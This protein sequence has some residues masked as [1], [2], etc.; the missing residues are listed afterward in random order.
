[1]N[2]LLV[3]TTRYNHKNDPMGATFIYEQVEQLRL[4]FDKVLV[5]AYRPYTPKILSFLYSPERK[6]DSLAKNYEYENV[7]VIYI[8]NFV[9]PFSI[10]RYSWA[11]KGFKSTKKIFNKYLFKPNIIHAHRTWPIG[12]I[13]FLLS[14]HLKTK[15]F[16]TA[17]GYDAYGLYSKSKYYR[18]KIK[19]CLMH[20]KKVISVSKKNIH[21]MSHKMNIPSDKFVFISNGYDKNKFLPEGDTNNK[22]N[23]K[24][25]FLSIG[26]LHKIKGHSILIKAFDAVSK[27]NSNV[28]L[29][30]IGDGPERKN[31]HDLVKKFN[32]D[33]RVKLA[34]SVPH[35]EIP[36]WINLS[37]FLVLP[38]L[39]EGM[40]TVMLEALGCGKPVIAT[41]VGGIPEIINEKIGVLVDKDNPDSLAQG[42]LS[43]IN[44]RWDNEYILNYSKDY[45]WQN[46]AIKIL[47]LYHS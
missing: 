22:I 3:L 29:N 16:I 36:K 27:E 11:K 45:S 39:N 8:K 24:I 44:Q 2:N 7:Q 12:E 26:F 42:L 19:N 30:I 43:A 40:P 35:S 47:K 25:K 37:N 9:I 5:I 21:I 31:L 46:I 17:H 20:A 14:K 32:L 28:E 18:N 41:K 33:D 13:A 38:S 6:R 15:Y 10:F 34:G 4:S 1:M 23:G